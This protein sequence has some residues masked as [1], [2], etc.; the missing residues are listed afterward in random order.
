MIKS[1]LTQS[2]LIQW[3]GPEVFNRALAYVNSGSVSRA[4]Y[5]DEKL[6]IRGNIVQADG[7]EMPV[8]CHLEAN[9]RIR[10]GCTCLMNQKYGQ[11]CAHVVAI[12]IAVMVQEMDDIE[13]EPSSPARGKSA[14]DEAAAA[15][16]EEP[17]E[18]YIRVP[19]APRFSR[20]YRGRGHP[21]RLS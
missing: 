8:V 19:M 16:P 2:E 11:I 10:S 9:G 13:P 14:A 3:G 1:G 20:L 12:G 21:F 18:E 4:V 6:E 5:D 17:E 7:W 15:E